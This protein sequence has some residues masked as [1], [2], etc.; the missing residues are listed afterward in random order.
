MQSTENIMTDMKVPRSNIWHKI[1]V[2]AFLIGIICFLY[3]IVYFRQDPDRAMYGYLWAF[4]SV[5]SIALGAMFFVLI[6]HITRAGWSIV[7]RRV[8]EFAMATV[9]LFVLLFIPVALLSTDIFSWMHIDPS[10]VMLVNKESYLNLSFF[11]IR[12]VIYFVI[13]LAIG[14]WFFKKSVTQDVGNRP[15]DS[16]QMISMSA[17]AIILFSLALTFASFDWLMSLQPHWYSTI[18]GV[19]FFAGSFLAGLAFITMVLIGLQWSG[20]LTKTVTLEHYQDLGK[21]M[22]G[23]T[24]FWAYIGFSQFML[25][26]YASIPEETEFYLHRL[27][28][29]WQYASYALPV[30]NFFIPFFFL[31]SRHVKRVKGALFIFCAW[32][33]IAHFFDLFWIIMPN[34]GAHNVV[35]GGHV[36]HAGINLADV[37]VLVGMLS[38]FVAYVGY[39]VVRKNIIP[40]GDPRLTESLA[41]EN[42]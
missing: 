42:T 13:W 40:V 33:L 1:P 24:V 39:L 3:W 6:Q 31:M 8:A 11:T 4:T 16:R 26:W 38:F 29:G 5:L 17:P 35:P 10:D 12:A 36:P 28:H 21:L 9:P 19:Y 41:F 30:T 23:F 18:F 27:A 14:L 15:N 37:L 2:A 34:F 7:I 32:T 25:Y 22:F 20:V